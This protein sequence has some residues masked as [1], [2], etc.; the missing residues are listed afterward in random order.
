MENPSLRT[1][2]P[3][4]MV[5]IFGE[6]MRRRQ[7][8]LSIIEE[9][10]TSFGYESLQTPSVENA[11]VFDGHHGAGE[12]LL[13]KL[14]DA[15]GND[16]VLRYDMTVPLARFMAMHPEL[17]RPFKR[18]QIAQAFRDDEVDRGHFREFTQCDADVIGVNNLSADA[19]VIMMADLGLKR[20]GFKS[21]T[22]RISH[23]SILTGIADVICGQNHDIKWFQEILDKADAEV[24]KGK[25]NLRDGLVAN[26]LSE[27]QADEI[28]PILNLSGEPMV[29]LELL[30]KK[31]LGS[32]AV[33][34]GVHE[35]KQ[36]LSYL[37]DDVYANVAIDFTLA[38][39]ANYYTGF[40]LEGVVSDAPIGAV[41]G[42]GRYDDLLAAAGGKKE[43][44][45][46]MAF[47][48]DRIITAMEVLDFSPMVK[49]P[50]LLVFTE[51]GEMKKA[52]DLVHRLRQCGLSVDFNPMVLKDDDASNYAEGR[53][54]PAM[55][56]V[57]E[58]F[59]F[60]QLKE[61]LHAFKRKVME[62]LSS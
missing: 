47:G 46:G 44:A 24:K 8:A 22:I 11:I 18:F 56:R 49:N 55:V 32:L 43:P 31:L 51:D 45:V 4:G 35:L 19:E 9:L 34:K 40:I 7:Y 23:R 2:I 37:P 52:L 6:R 16:L 42:G 1:S 58:R 30:W 41:L 38:R 10:Y 29:K 5:D 12:K 3:S 57:G 53:G 20:I 60:I 21:Y 33:Q 15:G 14:K 39:G 28:F 26:G 36:I 62:A 13:F 54:Y 27:S 50:T 61:C 48:L 17:K 59:N 25:M